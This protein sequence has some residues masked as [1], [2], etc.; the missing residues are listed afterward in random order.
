MKKEKKGVGASLGEALREISYMLTIIFCVLRA[1][2]VITW[3]WYWVM[4]PLIF[5]WALGLSLLF[6]LG[7]ITVDIVKSAEKDKK[8]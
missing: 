2:D 6:I 5:S 4:S 3:P 8:K 1:C 7:A